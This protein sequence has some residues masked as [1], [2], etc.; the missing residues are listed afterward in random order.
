MDKLLMTPTHT[1]QHTRL[2]M[3]KCLVSRPD[4]TGLLGLE[5]WIRTFYYRQ[6]KF[7]ENVPPKGGNKN[8]KKL[9]APKQA[10][11]E[12]SKKA[13]KEKVRPPPPTLAHRVSVS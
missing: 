12:A 7:G 2:L 13:K 5:S 10:I 4:P 11:K 9:K 1:P 6:T 3:L 8:S